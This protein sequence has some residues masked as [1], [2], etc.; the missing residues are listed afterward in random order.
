M[1]DE[2]LTDRVRR[3]LGSWQVVTWT[4]IALLML[5]AIWLPSWQALA[6]AA[7][8]MIPALALGWGY[9]NAPRI[10]RD[11]KQRNNP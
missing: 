8:L 5:A 9:Q 1:T 6:T 3:K 4:A 2:S 7:L 10:V 11:M